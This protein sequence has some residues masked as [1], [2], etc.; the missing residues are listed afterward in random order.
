[1]TGRKALW[2]PLLPGVLL[3]LISACAPMKP[4]Q[5]PAVAKATVSRVAQT[6]S[7]G[8]QPFAAKVLALNRRAENPDLSNNEAASLVREMNG[9]LHAFLALP[10]AA[11]KAPKLQGAITRMCDLCLQLD[12]DANALPDT[13]DG[14]LESPKEKLLNMTTFISPAKLKKT[15]EEVKKASLSSNSGLAIPTN[16]F[17]LTYVHLYQTKFRD[18]FARALA[19][20]APYVPRMK[21]IFRN[22]GVP[23]ALV[24]LAIVESGFHGAA[25]SRAG[26]VGMWQFISSTARLY[27]MKVDFWEDQR[28]DPIIEGRAAARYLKDLH[29]DSGDWLLALAAYNTGEGRIKRFLARSPK[30]DFW[31]LLRSRTIRRETREYV[32]AILAAILIASN[33]KDY[34]FSPPVF[35]DPT[36]DASVVIHKATDVRVLAKCAG[37]SVRALLSLNPSLRRFLTPP[38]DY[39]LRIPPERLDS[40]QIALAAIPPSERVPVEIHTVRSGETLGAIARRYKVSVGAIRVANRIR[41]HIIRPRQR[42]IIPLGYSANDPA[43]YYDNTRYSRRESKVYRVRRGDTLSGI[44]R[45]TGVTVRSLK[46]LNNLSSD[47]LRPGQHLVLRNSIPKKATRRLK[48]QKATGGQRI[49]HVKRGDTLW[50]LARKFGTSVDKICRANRISPGRRLQLGDN[51]LI[52]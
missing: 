52:P 43:L 3:L 25:R 26:A 16:R 20:G 12:L 34:G 24:Y 22:E 36:P 41:G 46:T 48:A 37:I 50:K 8:S 1:M 51:L 32:P 18:W 10:A 45:R 29:N 27:G 14:S 40:F 7:S 5:P 39:R 30:G 35:E 49:H 19:N 28:R 47:F 4:P 9:T 15:Y 2:K 6:P 23:P 44:S 21:E 31:K 42:L 33:P 13:P 11:G 38:R 17:V